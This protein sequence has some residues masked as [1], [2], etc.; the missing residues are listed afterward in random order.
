[1]LGI[2]PRGRGYS[3]IL[4]TGCANEVKLL[5]PKKVLQARPW[6]KKS[7]KAQNVTPKK[8]N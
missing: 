7:P 1:M 5:D 4:V 8:S 3:G 6:P 2:M